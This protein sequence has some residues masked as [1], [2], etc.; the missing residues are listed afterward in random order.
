MNIPVVYEDE[1]LLIVDK[2]AGML[3]I[4]TPR[5]EKRTL[6]SVL[7]DDAK[8]KGRLER[9][10]PCHRLDRETSGVMI[11]AKGKSSQQKMME[12]FKDRRV[13]K[14]YIAA[15]QGEVTAGRGI[16]REPLAGKTAVTRYTL[17]RAFP[18][19]SVVS[20][21]PVTGRRN[22][23]RLHFKHIGHP[24]VGESRFAFRRDS[25]LKAPR[26]L[27]HAVSVRFPHPYTGAMIFAEAPLS[28]DMAVFFD[29][30]GFQER[31]GL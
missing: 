26:A 15:V 5:R 6:T 21:E 4:P 29:T 7:N 3:S 20:V 30:H 19:Y 9:L 13:H 24:L 18:E 16:I 25:V 31:E 17:V 14:R 22:Q 2:P 28:R 23:I 27:L 10:H 12:A 11:Y 1:W 8:E